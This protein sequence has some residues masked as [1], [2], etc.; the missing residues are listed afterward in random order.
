MAG[1]QFARI[2]KID[3]AGI[4]DVFAG[5]GTIG[6]GGDGGPATNAQFY[7]ITGITTDRNGNL[8]VG[9]GAD[10]THDMHTIRKIDASGTIT[11]F[12]GSPTAYGFSG[13][14]GPASTALL[15]GVGRMK[16]DDA[17]N[18]YF[19]DRENKRIRKIDPA[20]IITTV[21]GNGTTTYT[22]D[23][24][25]ATATGFNGTSRFT[26]DYAGNIYIA[27]PSINAIYKVNTAG[28]TSTIAGNGVPPP[29]VGPF[30]FYGDGGPA[31]NARFMWMN[32]I[33]AD[34]NGNLF[35]ID[36]DRIRVINAAGIVKKIAGQDIGGG[37]SGDGGFARHA[38]LDGPLKI[39]VTDDGIIYVGEN[40]NH[41]LRKLRFVNWEPTFEAGSFVSLA[42][43]TIGSSFNLDTVLRVNDV[44]SADTLVWTPITSPSNGTLSASYTMGSNTG[45]AYPSGLS[46][47]ASSGYT[48]ADSFLVQVYD[49]YEY[50]TIKVRV[51]IVSPTSGITSA[52]PTCMGYTNSFYH[53]A[54][55]GTWSSSAPSV[56]TVNGTTGAITTVSTGTSVITYTVYPGCYTTT[57]VTLND[58]PAAI[59]GPSYVCV[60]LT[61]SLASTTPGGTWSSSNTAFATVNSAGTVTGISSG[62]VTISYT[63]S[64]GC[65]S[66]SLMDVFDNPSTPTGTTTICTGSTTTLTITMYPGGTWS[67]SDP[68]VATIGSTGEV[69][70]VSPGT[71]T[72]TYTSPGGCTSTTTITVLESPAAITGT[73]IICDGASTTLSNTTPG[74]TWSSDYTGIATINS[75]G[76]ATSVAP[77]G[78]IISYML[79]NGCYAF[80]YLYVNE[81]PD[82]ITGPS[83]ICE[84]NNTTFSSTTPWGTWSSSD[85]AVAVIYPTSGYMYGNTAGTATISYLGYTG[86]AATLTITVNESPANITGP[87]EV[88]LAATVTLSTTSSGGTWSSSIPTTASISS[89]GTVEGLA[90][91]YSYISY[92]YPNGCFAMSSISVNDTPSAITGIPSTCVGE[93]VTL[94]STTP[95][96]TWSSS[97]ASIVDVPSSYGHVH[98]LTEGSVTVSYTNSTTGCYTTIA[99]TVHDTASPITGI[100]DLCTGSNVVLSC[101]PTGGTWSSFAPGIASVDATTGMVT[102][103]SANI[104]GLIYTSPLNCISYVIV[105]VNSTPAST[106]TS[107]AL[108][109]GSS[110]FL[111]SSDTGGTWN[112]ANPTVATINA[113]TGELTAASAGT[114]VITYTGANGCHTQTIATVNPS[115]TAIMGLSNVCV[116]STLT[117]WHSVTGGTW[118]SSNPAIGSIDATGVITGISAGSMYVTYT[119][120]TGCYK[121]KL[122]NVREL[123]TITGPTIVCRGVFTPYSSS[124]AGA[125]WSASGSSV[126]ISTTG[127]FRGRNAGTA[128]ITC[129][130]SY[131]C[132]STLTVT[133]VALPTISGSLTVCAGAS[134][135]LTAPG[136][137]GGTWLSSNSTVATIGA[138]TGTMSG[139]A[140]GTSTITY[141]DTNTCTATAVATV[142]TGPAP[143]TLTA[144]PTGSIMVGGT[145]T[146]TPSVPGGTWNSGNT[147]VAT[148]NSSGIVTGVGGGNASISYTLTDAC[149]STV[150]T[151]KVIVLGLKQAPLG[152]AGENEIFAL[153]PNPTTGSISMSTAFDGTCYIYAAD[154]RQVATYSLEKGI[155]QLSLPATLSAGHYACKVVAA[156]GETRTVKIELLR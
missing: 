153:Y 115:L 104:S 82:P 32:D 150:T 28:I 3:T 46:Y 57:T 47:T 26:V 130:S 101:L 109:Y 53:S 50:D 116:G 8:F 148:V 121:T 30:V 123:P 25:V 12:A 128:T 19:E 9:N 87:G 141:T 131:G 78:T 21:A 74:G 59:T 2:R 154:G 145:Q 89:T 73:T 48:G 49:G 81:T 56:L 120:P 76:V 60:G 58:V 4:I 51:T 151:K 52:V 136:Y 97:N 86:C 144:S 20:G 138:S 62:L 95:Y 18:L 31:T 125:T 90:T 143:A 45:T 114:A 152:G 79:A 16:T 65:S 96:G 119:A 68:S 54:A 70:G 80:D 22:G 111:T 42:N 84:G 113:T 41:I 23:G 6:F 93:T 147:A 11:L 105:T 91:G 118:S 61:N 139:I 127:T 38:Q 146:M 15:H 112:S 34:R 43:C 140:G 29:P 124:D 63:N 85:P 37:Y 14:G 94:S 98:G 99:F 69:T 117:V 142:S 133:V 5:N 107:A 102:G 27:C 71:S 135:T 1:T 24:S 40:N 126:S 92:T 36:P 100:F 106:I 17:G 33:A 39:H 88:C 122:I 44:D 134:T 35:V 72:I 103:V 129:T 7:Q 156:D 108:C 149:G 67:S 75:A 64:A 155:N 110:A 66:F 77:G 55:G 137:T 13:D 132:V 10:Y 83:I